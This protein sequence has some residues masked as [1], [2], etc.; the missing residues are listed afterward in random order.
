MEYGPLAFRC[1]HCLKDSIED[2]RKQ[3]KFKQFMSN[4]EWLSDEAD[5]YWQK[6]GVDLSET[7]LY[8]LEDYDT[9]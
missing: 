7:A 9:T 2:E 8:S 1:W 3:R 6:K 4:F 5:K